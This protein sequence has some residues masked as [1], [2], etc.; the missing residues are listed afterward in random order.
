MN[1]DQYGANTDQTP[2]PPRQ[3]HGSSRNVP[4]QLR[5]VPDPTR[6]IVSP[7]INTVQL[8]FLPGAN[9]IPSRPVSDYPGLKKTS[10]PVPNDQGNFKQFK[11]AG[12]VHDHPGLSQTIP[13]KPG[14]RERGD[15]E[16]GGRE[17][18]RAVI[19]S[20]TL[21]YVHL[22]RHNVPQHGTTCHNVVLARQAWRQ[23]G[24]TSQ[25]VGVI[26]S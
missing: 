21:C 11:C 10:R 19:V 20:A 18:E 9:T 26:K 25:N 22:T 23:R 15:R 3:R 5:T 16:R 1:T 4:N 12:V 6:H 7:R 24:V 13:D 17:R 14:E 8:R 2:V